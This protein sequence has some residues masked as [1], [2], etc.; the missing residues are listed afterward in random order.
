MKSFIRRIKEFGFHPENVD[1]KEGCNSRSWKGSSHGSVEDHRKTIV[2]EEDASVQVRN[3]E[4]L[5]QGVRGAVTEA[6]EVRAE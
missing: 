6:R 5:H 4:G 1:F 2:E 3:G